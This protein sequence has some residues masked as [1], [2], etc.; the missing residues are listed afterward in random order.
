MNQES[1]QKSNKNLNSSRNGP[2]VVVIG[3]GTGIHGLLSGLKKYTDNIT[4]VITMMDSGGSSGTLRDEFGHLPPGDSRQALVALM[5][6]DRSS[7]ML[8]RLFNFRFSKGN[9]LEG[10]SFGNLFLTALT[11]ISGGVDKAITEAGK[12]LGIKGK[13]LPVTMTHSNL[14]ARLEDGNEITGESN[15]DVRKKGSGIP[16]DYLYL[17]P[18]AYVYPP[19]VVAIEDA[20]VIV[21]GPGD[22]YTSIV[23]NL[24]VDGVAEAINFSRAKKIY[25][26]N[27][28]TKHGESDEFKS[29]GFISEIKNY[30]ENGIL[31]FAIINK[32][33][34]PEKILKRYRQEKAFPVKID[35]EASGKLAGKLI[36]KDIAST[37]NLVRH[38][39]GKIARLVINIAE[40]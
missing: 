13:V 18:I 39:P 15:I 11:E 27:L 10:H 19:V 9:G 30:L 36:V 35:M 20:D 12:L 31:D 25:I 38:D 26:C 32:S 22:L 21:L 14:V 5:P 37:G 40:G 33:N 23:P 8:R 34:F 29:S 24:L 2:K 28:M 4:A 17:D 16:I 1:E 7:L 3:G 6:D